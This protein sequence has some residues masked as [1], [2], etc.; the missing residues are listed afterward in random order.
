MFL[1]IDFNSERLHKIISTLTAIFSTLYHCE[2]I[3]AAW[4]SCQVGARNRA[5]ELSGTSSHI[6]RVGGITG[7]VLRHTIVLESGTL[8]G[9]LRFEHAQTIVWRRVLC[10][11][12]GRSRRRTRI[13]V[14]NAIRGGVFGNVFGNVLG[15]CAGLTS[16]RALGASSAVARTLS[17]FAR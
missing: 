17:S 3:V 2:R 15:R 7:V 6:E 16:T 10:G 4:S 14:H 1:R 13:A 5:I 12:V 9:E 8:C 11:R